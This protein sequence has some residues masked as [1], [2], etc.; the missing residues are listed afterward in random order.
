MALISSF[1]NKLRPYIQDGAKIILVFFLTAAAVIFLLHSGLTIA[2]PYPLDYGEAPLIDQAMRL[3]QGEN[4]YRANLDTPPYTIANYPPLYVLTL[5]PF[6]NWFGSPFHMAR[7]VS[8]IST[9]LSALFIGLTIFTFT[10]RSIPFPENDQRPEPSFSVKYLPSVVAALFFLASP[11]VVQW[12][13]LARIDSLALMFATAALYVLARW[14]KG[15]WAWV[16]GGLLLVAAAYTR[17]SYLLAAPLA[18]AAWLFTQDKRRALWLT[19]LVGGLGLG[20]FFLLNA[21]T[22]GGFYYNIVTANVNEF[23]WDRLQNN[24]TS[25]WHVSYIIL[26]LGALYLLIG[27]RTQ[28]SWPLV[29]LFLVGASLSALTIG[30]IGSNINYFLELAA[31]LALIAGITLV[32]SRVHPWRYLAVIVLLI[33]QFG[34]LMENAM[35][36]D[37]DYQLSPRLADTDAL[38]MLEQ[39]VKTTDGPILADEYM[40]L[41][42]INHRALY[43]QPF[44]V[45]QLANEGMWNEQP[46]LDELA[47][48]KFGAVLIHHF[49]PYPLQ[50][51]RW[52]PAM[53]AA[54]DAHYRP[55]KT[56]AGTVIYIPR[57]QTTISQIPDPV[58]STPTASPPTGLPFPLDD[59]SFFAEPSLALN[60]VNPDQLV[61]VATRFSK[62]DCVLPTCKVDM[63]F[64]LSTDGGQ[65]WQNTGTFSIPQQVFYNGQVLF[66][67]DGALYIQA[68]RNN[69]LVL[70][71]LP[72]ADTFAPS[73]GKFIEAPTGGG[74]ARPW[75]LVSPQNGELYLSFDAQE[76]DNQ[77]LTPALKHSADG[78]RWSLTAR[79]DQHVSYNDS[80]SPRATGPSDIRVLFGN[81]RDVSLIW[82]WDPDPWTWPRTV[83]M[84]NSTDGGD[85]FGEPTP[86][87]KTWGPISVAS[88]NGL[89]ALAYRT[90]DATSQ[91]LAVATTSNNGQTWTSIIAS[92]DLPLLF[93]AD[94]APII[95]LAPNGTLDLAFYAHTG[96]STDCVQ[97]LSSWQNSLLSFAADTCQYNV[98][99]TFSKDRGQTFSEPL[100]LNP[101]PIR[102]EDFPSFGGL[103]LTNT[104]LSLA[105]SDTYAYPLWVGT[106]EVGKTQ[107]FTI[108]IKR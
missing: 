39:E 64:Y 92:A 45:S 7:A 35:R 77:F 78:M 22:H 88:A 52:T 60:P 76:G 5:V 12:S 75:L 48:Q 103:L 46:L 59:T 9:I 15:R 66:G 51:E 1:F 94:H 44:E 13:G 24:L 40:G 80:F 27:W 95:S 93:D 31:A 47:A 29:A 87:S 33:M 85:T 20:L 6:L 61:A 106:P 38:K 91:H 69:N 28:K 49:D 70:N 67:P 37:V 16:G 2:H 96:D 74:G 65:T 36:N 83:W 79:A 21:L 71:Q 26:L 54:I 58:Q 19:L 89:F 4:I 84:A 14:P 73:Q 25:L 108:K 8:V 101:T 57:G 98:Y 43:L 3:A 68:K 11:Y 10:L 72:P 23:G 104:Y 55:F 17:Q 34:L 86:I 41:L 100:Q 62:Q 97:T 90:G 105:S 63:P 18:G 53:L 81:G 99:Y 107:V 82:V 102:G 32:W 50:K 30:K 42:T 56:I